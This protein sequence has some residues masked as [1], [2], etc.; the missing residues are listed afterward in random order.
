MD[1]ELTDGTMLLATPVAQHVVRTYCDSQM[2][3]VDRTVCSS[4]VHP[5]SW[6]RITLFTTIV[7]AVT[8]GWWGLTAGTRQL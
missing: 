4:S 3:S 2:A 6:G 8:F 5:W 7:G 1:S